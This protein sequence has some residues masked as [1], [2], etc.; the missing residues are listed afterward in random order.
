MG[1]YV[2]IKASEIPFY[3]SLAEDGIDTYGTVS[4]YW[5]AE[6]AKFK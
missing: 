3:I 2:R 1:G 6:L 5:E 4:E